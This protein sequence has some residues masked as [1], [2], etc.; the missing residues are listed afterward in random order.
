MNS[1]VYFLKSFKDWYS[2][3]TLLSHLGRLYVRLE[4]GVWILQEGY[5]VIYTT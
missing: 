3:S 1:N 4:R 5:E 2:H